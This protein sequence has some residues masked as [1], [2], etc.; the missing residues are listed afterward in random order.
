MSEEPKSEEVNGTSTPSPTTDGRL[1][2]I[3]LDDRPFSFVV[4]HSHLKDCITHEEVDL[5]YYILFYHEFY[6]FFNLLGTLFGFVAS[7][8]EQ[9]VK[10]LK[11]LRESEEH[12]HQLHTVKSMLDYETENSLH[13]KNP[14][15]GSRTL[16]RLHRALNFIYEFLTELC[17]LEDEEKGLSHICQDTYNRTL[18]HF[19]SWPIRKCV[20]MAAYAL[21]TK[22]GLMH[23]AIQD[24]SEVTM[25]TEIL[26]ETLNSIQTVY[27][28]CQ[29]MYLERELHDLP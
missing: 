23:K 11:G 2:P 8:V 21:P 25:I 15:N 17:A 3:T 19:H 20:S 4:L 14:N 7:D 22:K 16:L 1:V 18:S 9:K 28:R 13:K 10:I 24:P 5:Q 29:Q 26:P 12:G 6:K 27:D